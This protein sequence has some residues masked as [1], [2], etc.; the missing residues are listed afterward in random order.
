MREWIKQYIRE[1]GPVD[2]CD[3]A[4]HEEFYQRFGGARKETTFGAQ[5]VYKA[6]RTLKQMSDDGE[7]SRGIIGLGGNWQPGFP[8]WCYGYYVDL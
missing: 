6:M 7:I 2:V 8:K 1:H 4:F 3:T 5:P